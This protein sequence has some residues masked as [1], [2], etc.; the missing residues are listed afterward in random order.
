MTHVKH[1][2]KAFK[3][4]LI[5]RVLIVDDAY[6]PPDLTDDVLAELADFLERSENSSAL[7]LEERTLAM[8]KD[9]I[10]ESDLA[11]HE[12]K[13][14]YRMLYSM[15]ISRREM[16]HL[17]ALFGARK[18]VAIRELQ[19]LVKLLEQCLEESRV[20]KAGLSGASKRF[21]QLKPQV[22]FLDYYLSPDVSSFNNSG[23][24]LLASARGA[25]QFLMNEFLDVDSTDEIPEVVL[26]STHAISDVDE[27]R[28]EVSG[29]H[30]TPM[31]LRFHYLRKQDL[32]LSRSGKQVHLKYRAFYTLLDAVQGF[33]FGRAMQ[34]ALFGWR[35]GAMAAL[36]EFVEGF[37]TLKSK[38]FAYLIRFRLKEEGQPL[39]D[40]V[41]WLFG[42]YLKSQIE[43]KVDWDDSSFKFLDSDHSSSIEGAVE[44]PS[45]QIAKFFHRVRVDQRR[46]WNDQYRLGDLYVQSGSHVE[47]RAVITPDCDLIVHRAKVEHLLTVKGEIHSFRDEGTGVDD[48]LLIDNR[49]VTV[50]WHPKN[51]ELFPM[52]GEG[53]LRRTMQYEY[54]GTLRPLYALELQRRTIADLS[55]VGLPVAPA[56]GINASAIVWRRT[57]NVDRPFQEIKLKSSNSV[58]VI[59]SRSGRSEAHRVLLRCDFLYELIGEIT[60]LDHSDM[61]GNDI[62]AAKKL[63]KAKEVAILHKKFLHDGV[64][65]GSRTSVVDVVVGEVPSTKG[66][67]AWLQIGIR[68][69]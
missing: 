28:G 68:F 22:V 60:S 57:S 10:D 20:C 30:G 38:D 26:M 66:E 12:L 58:T 69:P 27:Y 42:E 17:S 19:P 40:Y 45:E 67:S 7:D 4:N 34:R 8:A 3:A 44:G 49:P 59:P 16:G 65:I 41:N 63:E 54:V 52:N 55:R 9:A 25:S 18:A 35:D 64:P 13:K 6:D 32:A 46:D 14:V 23:R 51:L 47:V 50:E 15:Y 43:T 5:K 39:S 62:S 29:K 56:F 36:E 31:A 21:S 37:A 24:G 2:C 61:T 1:I 33:R 53:T 11:N 48:F